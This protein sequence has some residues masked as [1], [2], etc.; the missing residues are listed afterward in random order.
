MKTTKYAAAIIILILFGTLV[1]E[2]APKGSLVIIGGGLSPNNRTVFITFI[3]LGGGKE[4]IRLAIIPAASMTP[5]QSGESHARDFISHGIPKEHIKIFPIAVLDDPS[6]NDTDESKW[7]DNGKNLQLAEEIRRYNAVFFVGG[8]QD[9]YRQVFIDS[10]GNDF[11]V[12]AAIREIYRNGGVLGGTS[13]G[14]AI[15]SDPMLISGNP[16]E[17]ILSGV[18]YEFPPSGPDP[19]KQTRLTKG[20]GFFTPGIVDQHFIKRGRIGRLIPSLLYVQKQKTHVLG[21]GIDEDTALVYKDKTVT[22]VGSSGI[23]IIDAANAE[24]TETNSGPRIK[25]IIL[26]YLENGDSFNIETGNFTI[27]PV[28]KKIEKGKEYYGN[29]TLDTN[30]LGKDAVKE[31]ITTGLIDC[32]QQ[33]AEGLAFTLLPDGTG[34]G[35]HMT[36]S[37]TDNTAGY[38]AEINE[39]ETFSALYISFECFPITIDVKLVITPSEPSAK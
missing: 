6:T 22:V 32:K 31:L 3:E 30:V 39:I 12:L 35:M 15:M 17:T 28:R 16:T 23:I 38:Y 18:V 34:T 33:K 24:V 26:H 1:A 27:N 10:K 37:K 2:E 11:P 4:N 19:G 5:V 21:F 14:A 7:I 8:D 25:N 36:F 13:A 20:S 9:R 29:N